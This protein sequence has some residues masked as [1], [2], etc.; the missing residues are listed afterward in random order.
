MKKIC[1]LFVILFVITTMGIAGAAEKKIIIKTPD[2]IIQTEDTAN[3]IDGKIKIPLNLVKDY[4]YQNMAIDNPNKQVLINF[5]MPKIKFNNDKTN[6]LIFNGFKIMYPLEKINN[7]DYLNIDRLGLLLGISIEENE[8]NIIITTNRN[9]YYNPVKLNYSATNDL[10]KIVMVWQPILTESAA[11]EK[12]PALNILSPSW[13]SIVSADGMIDNKA[14]YQYSVMAKENK[15]KLWP[16]ITNSFDP[17]LTHK[18]L[19]NKNARKN[20]IKQ[21]VV[22][23][24]LYE[25]DGINFDFENIYESDRELLNQFMLEAT[26]A[27]HDINVK[28]S[29]DVTAPMDDSQWSKC[30]DRKTLGKIVDYVMLM[31]Y[32]EH[33][34]TS[35]VSGSVA[36][37]P[38]VE[39]G[40]VNT[41]KDVPNEK[42]V[43]GL[44]FY[45]R[46]WQEQTVAGKV[47]VKAKTVAMHEIDTIIKDKKLK[48]LWL[49]D[50]GQEYVQYQQDGA[51]YKIW[52]E[53]EKSLDKKINLVEKYNLAGVAA[54]RKGFEKPEVWQ[55]LEAKLN[56]K[57]PE[58]TT[59]CIKKPKKKNKKSTIT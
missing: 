38:W 22:Y 53:N 26:K 6:N 21:L 24:G 12:F 11:T 59:T 18:F 27:L 14:D 58:E 52:I 49:E 19:N 25:V 16:L 29:I 51:I 46:E 15:Y 55:L 43:L 35:T 50:K 9:S 31:A 17:D 3:L 2:K 44:P 34:R 36:S 32:D 20:I 10:A 39:N 5:S 41:L 4:L 33:W 56:S 45:M 8:D 40:V 37:L 30:Y 54:W 47:K 23:A 13:F 42:L 7:N 1:C 57:V 28:V 48:P